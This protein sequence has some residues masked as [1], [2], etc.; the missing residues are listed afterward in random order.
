[1]MT[2]KWRE[3]CNMIQHTS[4]NSNQVYVEC[5][6]L[7]ERGKTDRENKQMSETI[8]NNSSYARFIEMSYLF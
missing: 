5:Y 4:T 6:Q 7:T 3:L 2:K 8:N 1:M